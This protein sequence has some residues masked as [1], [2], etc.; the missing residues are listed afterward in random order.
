MQHQWVIDV[1]AD[2]RDYAVRNG[3]PL[4]AAKLAEA[5]DTARAEI[6]G[7]DPGDGRGPP[8]H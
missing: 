1:L 3:L 7:G 2:A 6:A 8:R 5:L 4:L